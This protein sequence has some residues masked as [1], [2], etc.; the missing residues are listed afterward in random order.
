[1]L[2]TLLECAGALDVGTLS[3]S[4]RLRAVAVET[5]GDVAVKRGSTLTSADGREAAVYKG[6]G[7]NA[8]RVN[9][10]YRLY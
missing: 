10:H 2:W 7:A 6:N 8:R 4:P 9:R 1:M 3:F 5:D